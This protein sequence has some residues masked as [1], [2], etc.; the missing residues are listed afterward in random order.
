MRLQMISIIVNTFNHQSY[1]DECIKSIIHQKTTKNIQLYILDD[2]S[3][4][5]TVKVIK[6]TIKEA[7]PNFSIR[8]IVNNENYYSKGRMPSIDVFK[9]INTDLCFLCDG[10]DYW[11]SKNKIETQYRY[12][13]D[14]KNCYLSFHDYQKGN[15]EIRDA[16]IS[17]APKSSVNVIELDKNFLRAN[18]VPKASTFCVRKEL[19]DDHVNYFPNCMI[20][21]LVFLLMA[22]TRGEI[23]AIRNLF[24]FYRINHEN[25]HTA[26]FSRSGQLKSVIKRHEDMYDLIESSTKVADLRGANN[27]CKISDFLKA[28][29]DYNLFI[30]TQKIQNTLFKKEFLSFLF[31]LKLSSIF[32]LLKLR[33]F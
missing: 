23:V 16:Q 9:M 12:M 13:N 27:F 17:N 28:R 1:I 24:S 7:P 22:S 6:K 14:N 15:S 32:N 33:C 25:S 21:D 2:A 10:D 8:L 11:I 19:L 4:D 26:R 18:T 3:T 29:S 5:N 20:G 30:S 31:N